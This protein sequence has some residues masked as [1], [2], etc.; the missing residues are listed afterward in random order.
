MRTQQDEAPLLTPNVL[1]CSVG[2]E[3]FYRTAG[4]SLLPDKAWDAHLDAGWDRGAAEAVA[5]A[6]PQL[7]R[8]VRGCVCTC[9]AQGAV[10][11]RL[12]ARYHPQPHGSSASP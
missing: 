6:I 1:I 9:G 10:C 2:T 4:G 5:A 7:K 11:I 3:I 12:V 8:Q